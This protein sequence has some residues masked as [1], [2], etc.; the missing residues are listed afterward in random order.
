VTT[1]MKLRTAVSLPVMIPALILFVISMSLLFL[2]DVISGRD[3]SKF[4]L[5]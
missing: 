4:L 3:L 5:S 2:V 1:S